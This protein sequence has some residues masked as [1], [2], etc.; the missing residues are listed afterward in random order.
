MPQDLEN[1]LS[2]VSSDDKARENKLRLDVPSSGTGQ[3]MYT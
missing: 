3:S 2:A 1:H